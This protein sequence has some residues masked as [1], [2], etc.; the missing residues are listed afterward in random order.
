MIAT[1]ER[2]KAATIAALPFRP[3]GQTRSQSTTEF[4]FGPPI[5]HVL[6]SLLQ[7][8]RFFVA[9]CELSKSTLKRLDFAR[10]HPV[11]LERTLLRRR[12]H[13]VKL[14]VV[15]KLGAGQVDDFLR[16]PPEVRHRVKHGGEPR[17]VKALDATTIN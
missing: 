14:V 16:M 3:A 5:F 13:E 10:L 4:R 2:R 6:T 17:N 9:V 8:T 11:R 15:P 1:L 12:R 7:A